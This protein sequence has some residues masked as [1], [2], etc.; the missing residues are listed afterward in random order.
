MPFWWWWLCILGCYDTK[1]MW[2]FI[3]VSLINLTSCGGACGYWTV[4]R[5]LLNYIQGMNSSLLAPWLHLPISPWRGQGCIHLH[6]QHTDGLLSWH[7]NDL[8]EGALGTGYKCT[9]VR[10]NEG[11]CW[12]DENGPWSVMEFTPVCIFWSFRYFIKLLVTFAEQKSK[13]LQLEWGDIL[14]KIN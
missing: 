13:S 1:L 7:D 8:E 10:G 12:Q 14:N 9:S 3:S 2:L 6:L 4:Q 11:Q 5:S